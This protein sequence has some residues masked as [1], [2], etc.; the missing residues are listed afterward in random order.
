MKDLASKT[1][2]LVAFHHNLLQLNV[3]HLGL[4]FNHALAV[5]VL[6]SFQAYII[7]L[8]GK[9][10]SSLVSSLHVCAYSCLCHFTPCYPL[11]RALAP[12]SSLCLCFWL[13]KSPFAFVFVFVGSC[14]ATDDLITALFPY[15]PF[16]ITTT[17]PLPCLKH[18]LEGCFLCFY[19][20][21]IY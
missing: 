11:S 13:T 7:V 6:D 19:I 2:L 5:V 16:L 21:L 14:I 8:Q 9:T 18:K 3:P 4:F 12:H 10:A 20:F 15:H 17:T 1:L